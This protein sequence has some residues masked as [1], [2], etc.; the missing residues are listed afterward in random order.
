MSDA[1]EKIPSGETVDEKKK[2]DS[3]AE[4]RKPERDYPAIL[5]VIELYHRPIFPKMQTPM[6]VM[7]EPSKKMIAD[8]GRKDV[9]LVALALTRSNVDDRKDE[10]PLDLYD[11]ATIAEITQVVKPEDDVPMHVMLSAIERIRIDKIVQEDPYI[12]AEVSYLDEVSEDGDELKAYSIAVIKSIKELISLNP[13]HKEELSIFLTVSTLDDPGRLADFSAALTSSNGHELQEILGLLSVHAR[14][15]KVL[16][17][18]KREI[19]ISKIQVKIN[20]QIEEKIDTQQREFFLRKQLDEIKKELGLEKEDKET[21]A[22]RFEKRLKKLKVSDE[23]GQVI[24]EELEKLRLIDSHSPEFSV[25]RNYLDWLTSLPWGVYTKDN[26]NLKRASCVLEKDH[27]GL[28]DVKERILEFLAVGVKKGNISGSIICFVGPP[29]VGKTSIGRSIARSMGRNFYRFSVGGIR[30]EAEIKGHRRTYI[31]ALPGK[32]IQAMKSC[33][34]SNPVI[35]I[36]EIDKIGASYQGD[37]ASALLEV[38]DPEQNNDFLDHYLDVRFD[39]SNVLFICT[40]N[41][42]DTIPR[43]LLDRME[44]IKIAGYVLKEKLEI[45]RRFLL[46]RQLKENGVDKAQVKITSA[47]LRAI[48]DGYAREPGVRGLDNHIRKI[49]RKCVKRL[50]EGDESSVK[51]DKKDVGAY[52]G[53]P[54]FSDERYYKTPVPGVVTGLAWTSM[55]GDTLFV[56]AALIHTGKAEFRQTGQLGDVMVESSEIAYHF[57]RAMLSDDPIATKLFSENMV[58]VHVPEG[59]TP[60]DGPSAGITMASA[61]Y[62]LVTRK[63]VINDLAMTGEL[64]LTGLVMPI[65]GVREKTMAARRAK[66]KHL[67]F[68]ERNRRDFNDLPEYIR[69]GMSASFV[70]RFVDVLG[71]AFAK[72]EPV[73]PPRNTI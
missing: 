62:S 3:S 63:P 23:A 47:A 19:D 25:C 61:I 53:K 58:H 30:D 9:K 66:I 2:L 64:T 11:I 42:L 7:E 14:L 70:S 65:G 52:L 24:Q 28:D 54:L 10:D 45:A 16:E 1:D 8:I 50:V 57:V 38:L 29:G 20:R 55:G 44:V 26:Y 5:P 60:K 43:P 49:I 59:A 12:M 67:I 51:I 18:L 6:V 21:E 36:D 41:Q 13:L 17:L 37:P 32:F 15:K 4:K 68:P 73:H 31:G 46:K 39:L 22:E 34:S 35:M 71:L 48:I 56:E 69:S 33:K 27:Y 40:A 72:D